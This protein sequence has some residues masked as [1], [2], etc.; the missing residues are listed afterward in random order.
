MRIQSIQLESERNAGLLGKLED[1]ADL[2]S[3][4]T[5]FIYYLVRLFPV[6]AIYYG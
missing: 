3:S 6:K 4:Y 1:V 2:V 5:T